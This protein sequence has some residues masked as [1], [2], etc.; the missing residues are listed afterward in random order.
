M[1]F[2]QNNL[3]LLVKIPLSSIIAMMPFLIPNDSSLLKFKREK[4]QPDVVVL[5]CN[6]S[7]RE[8]EAGGS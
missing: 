6:P 4:S 2:P 8:A 5:V 1:L 3:S 7:A